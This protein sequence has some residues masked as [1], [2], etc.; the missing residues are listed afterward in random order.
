MSDEESEIRSDWIKPLCD[1]IDPQ[2][3]LE[4]QS[5]SADFRSCKSSGRP[6]DFS[7]F[8]LE[9]SVRALSARFSGR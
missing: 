9:F 8:S 2:W 3:K 4:S 5:K 7:H 1:G 6:T